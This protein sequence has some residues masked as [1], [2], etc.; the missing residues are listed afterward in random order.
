MIEQALSTDP[1]K[2]ITFNTLYQKRKIFVFIPRHKVFF[3]TQS[4]HLGQM[5]APHRFMFHS[6]FIRS[7][8]IEL[9]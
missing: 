2:H 9:L 1:S 7:S 6:L 5:H 3:T 8:N 4:L